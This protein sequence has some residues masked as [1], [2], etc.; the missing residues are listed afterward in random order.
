MSY[1]VR[2][3]ENLTNNEIINKE[4]A[5]KNGTMTDHPHSLKTLPISRVSEVVIYIF[6]LNSSTF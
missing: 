4:H 1:K 2:M 3:I 5:R 6:C